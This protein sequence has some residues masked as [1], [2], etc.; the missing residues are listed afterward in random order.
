MLFP[1]MRKV[2][3]LKQID[4]FKFLFKEHVM[5]IPPIIS[6]GLDDEIRRIFHDE[7]FEEIEY[8]L[9]YVFKNKAYLISAF[10]HSSK[11]INSI[12]NSYERYDHLI[13]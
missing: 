6:E 9:D 12:M 13:F 11:S 5:G 3:F 2:K 8:K 7:G 1:W 10:T 4:E